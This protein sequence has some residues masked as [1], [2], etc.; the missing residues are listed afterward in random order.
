[1][2]N[3]NLCSDRMQERSP[4]PYRPISVSLQADSIWE[5]EKRKTKLQIQTCSQVWVSVWITRSVC[6][7]GECTC[8][9]LRKCVRLCGR[10]TVS[11]Q[12]RREKRERLILQFFLLPHARL[13]RGARGNLFNVQHLF[14]AH[15]LVHYR[16]LRRSRHSL[17]PGLTPLISQNERG[18]P[19]SAAA[20]E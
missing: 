2:A 20:Q 13:P 1:M 16:F 3:V 6:V 10:K 14:S 15:T 5:G 18:S 8:G 9:S 17:W 7:G 4:V 11:E 12:G 19:T